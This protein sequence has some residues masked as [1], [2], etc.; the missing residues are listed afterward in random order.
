M[1]AKRKPKINDFKYYPIFQKRVELKLSNGDTIED[2]KNFGYFPSNYRVISAMEASMNQAR[3]VEASVKVTG[4]YPP[5][6]IESSDEDKK[7]GDRLFYTDNN[8]ILRIS[9]VTDPTNRKEYVNL[10]CTSGAYT[11]RSSVQPSPE[12]KTQILKIPASSNADFIKL[13]ENYTGDSEP[14]DIATFNTLGDFDYFYKPQDIQY[15]N[16][17]GSTKNL[18]ILSPY[19]Y[20]IGSMAAYFDDY[21]PIEIGLSNF[22][23]ALVKEDVESY[24]T[25][26][27][28]STGNNILLKMS[29]GDTLCNEDSDNY[30]VEV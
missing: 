28:V 2:Y 18:Y 27:T 23:G 16:Q 22:R 5:F 21:C 11:T 1:K 9:S 10:L 25:E 15:I 4:R 20:Y 19:D 14:K 12:H 17:T 7:N 8:R 26:E 13:F 24:L 3:R 30:C 6:T 29:T